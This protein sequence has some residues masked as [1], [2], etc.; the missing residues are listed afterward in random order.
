MPSEEDK[1]DGFRE[2]FEEPNSWETGQDKRKEPLKE[3]PLM[4]STIET[5]DMALFDWLNTTLDIFTT[6][7]KGWKKVPLI[8]VANERAF[9]IKNNKDLR[10]ANGRLILPLMTVNRTSLIK[11]P[12]MKGVAWA[13]IPQ[14]NDARGGSIMMAR[15]INPDKTSNFA[16]NA[17]NNFTRGEDQ[18]FPL[19]NK[20]VVYN[21]IYTPVPTY[22]VGN[23]EVILH[24]EYQQQLNEMFSP[25]I[26][27]TGQINN[28]FIN[29]D[30]HKFEGFIEG[31]F[32]LDNNVVNMGEE[33]RKYRTTINLKIL[34]YVLGSGKNDE[35]PKIVIREN[36]VEVKIPRERVIMGDLRPWLKPPEKK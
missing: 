12:N 29:W 7:N 14:M 23:Y 19:K 2:Y 20:K 21:T 1:Y 13:H 35:R 26:T 5:I 9:Q 8:W 22:V 24:A 25:F 3:I 33:E 34:A 27:K 10:D 30:G 36:A 6:T 11:D 16:N 15:R 18:N 31:D 28:F 4:P 17:A 32:S